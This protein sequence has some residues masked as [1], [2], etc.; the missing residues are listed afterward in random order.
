MEPTNLGELRILTFCSAIAFCMCSCRTNQSTSSFLF[1]FLLEWNCSAGGMNGTV[2]S[3]I[4]YSWIARQ[5]HAKVALKC[6]YKTTRGFD[7]GAGINGAY[8]WILVT[9]LLCSQTVVVVVRTLAGTELLSTLLGWTFL[10]IQRNRCYFS[11]GLYERKIQEVQKQVNGYNSNSYREKTNR[12]TRTTSAAYVGGWDVRC[13]GI[14]R[15]VER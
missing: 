3:W 8:F 13:F 7:D 11:W 2:L 9:R 14:L 10:E 6:L 5:C 4:W 15:S 1:F 12:R